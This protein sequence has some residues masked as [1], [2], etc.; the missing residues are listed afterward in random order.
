MDMD[1][2]SILRSLSKVHWN[3]AARTYGNDH[4][5]LIGLLVQWWM[6]LSPGKHWALEGGPAFGYRKRGTGGGG[7]CD[8]VFCEERDVLAILEVEGTRPL[9]TIEKIGKFFAAE[10]DEFKTLRFSILLLYAYEAEGR[11]DARRIPPAGTPQVF[12]ATSKLSLRYPDKSIIVI[13]LDKMYERQSEGIRARNEYYWGTPSTI[14]GFLYRNG[15]QVAL[16]QFF[17]GKMEQE[18]YRIYCRLI[19]AA[20]DSETMAYAELAAATG[21]PTRGHQLGQRLAPILDAICS[22]EHDHGRP[23]L[24]AVVVRADT[25]IP[26]GG[27]FKMARHVGKMSSSDDQRRF[28]Q[29]EL[30]EIKEAWA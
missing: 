26:G 11:G 3:V 5:T 19:R 2:L 14:K 30:E 17:G 21:L 16:E 6:S 10:Y 1:A 13:T 24:S 7:Q 29:R 23:L 20:M 25:G 9:Y 28:W 8:A 4:A 18:T 27:F 12:E 15:E 22:Y